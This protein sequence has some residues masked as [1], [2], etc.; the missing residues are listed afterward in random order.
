LKQILSKKMQLNKPAFIISID[1]ELAWGF[2]QYPSHNALK[3]LDTNAEKARK[4]ID[5]LLR[6]FEKYEIP[7][8]WATVGHLFLDH[9]EKCN[10]MP[11]VNMPRFRKNWYDVDTCSNTKKDPLH[12]GRDI[13]EKILMNKIGHEIGYH[14]FSHIPF[15]DCSR[16]V[17]EAE[18]IEGIKLAKEFEITFKSFVFPEN[19][20]GHVDILKKYGFK[21]YRGECQVYSD[22]C[23]NIINHNFNRLRDRV[24]APLTEPQWMDGIIEIPGSMYLW[25]VPSLQWTLVPRFKQGIDKAINKGSIFHVFLHEWNLACDPNLCIYIDKLLKFVSNKRNEKKLQVLT[26]EELASKFGAK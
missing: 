11:H 24:I 7:A 23:Q 14:S 9:C 2:A 12:Y 3:I 25:D 8:T 16:E 21:V 20:V 6:S 19:K 4:A 13:I 15:S 18:I 22:E 26:M 10:G 17:A 5:F 1:L